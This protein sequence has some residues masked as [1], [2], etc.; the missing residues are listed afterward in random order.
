M[1]DVKAL[2]RATLRQELSRLKEGTVQ[3]AH[4]DGSMLVFDVSQDGTQ[5]MG[6]R[7]SRR[8]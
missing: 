4:I 7:L 6:P 5:K 1:A 2:L 3:A 8:S